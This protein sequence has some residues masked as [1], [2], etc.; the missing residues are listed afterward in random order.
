MNYTEFLKE[1]NVHVSTSAIKLQHMLASYVLE[2][3][4]FKKTF[5]KMFWT[6]DGG[7]NQ[8]G[9][10]FLSFIG[11]NLKSIQS[12]DPKATTIFEAIKHC[13]TEII[14]SKKVLKTEFTKQKVADSIALPDYIKIGKRN[15]EDF[16]VEIFRTTLQI[17][18]NKFDKELYKSFTSIKNTI[19]YS[20]DDTVYTISTNLKGE[21]LCLTPADY[22]SDPNCL[23][24]KITKD[25]ATNYEWYMN[26][27]KT[28]LAMITQ[29]DL[30]AFVA[31]DIKVAP[32]ES[33][34]INDIPTSFRKIVKIK[35]RF[36]K[37]NNNFVFSKFIVL[38]L[39]GYGGAM[40]TL[41]FDDFF[42]YLMKNFV[43][44]TKGAVRTQKE[45]LTWSNDWNSKAV[46]TWALPD[47]DTLKNAA[48]PK[49]WHDFLD[50][51]ASP[52]LMSRLY[53]YL[54]AIQD[55]S[56][57]AQQALII[58]D[59]GGT[60]K[61]VIINVLNSILPE[62]SLCY[63]SNHSLSENDTFGLSSANVQDSH[64]FVLTEYD[65]ESLNGQIGKALIA[66][67]PMTLNVKNRSSLYWSPKG[68]KFIATSN[69]GC[70]LKENAIRR[71]VIPI[72]FTRH[73]SVKDNFSNEQLNQ[74]KLT[75]KD[76]LNWCYKIYLECSLKNKK[77]EYI[78]MN[79][80][81][82]KAFLK[83]GELEM[84]ED[85]RILKAFSED[86][87]ISEHFS[88][89]DFSNSEANTDFQSVIDNLYERTNDDKDVIWMDDMRNN[90]LA[91][92]EIH[93]EYRYSFNAK[94]IGGVICMA[95]KDWV[96]FNAFMRSSGYHN[97]NV[98]RGKNSPKAWVGLKLIPDALNQTDTEESK[99]GFESF[100]DRLESN[101]DEVS[102]NWS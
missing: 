77:G 83:T 94:E 28:K 71:R 62:R 67:D 29:E 16:D 95:R 53:F 27:L 37:L 9:G 51:K 30:D 52:R 86:E 46:S 4:N 84:N 23:Y 20:C 54:G 50:N 18:P 61:G 81:Q 99:G 12:F 85:H 64:L 42:Q 10:Q 24:N 55:A 88:V 75:A 26:V 45:Y 63:L 57:T 80:E 59:N 101:N 87:E 6:R 41:A 35:A 65:G 82:E 89:N 32:I 22:G 11:D 66:S 92:M 13:F 33:I 98:R 8:P 68:N 73:H 100:T 17:T 97:K 78:V 96:P 48:M 56:N 31:D 70:S 36:D 76:F 7:D 40:P 3:T 91:Y 38:P 69:A 5:E 72:S 21:E 102:D 43:Q 39:N 34:F 14:E 60:G 1:K 93:P 74:L 15:Y 49:C 90:I 2:P 58:S 79:P 25:M 44:M 19:V 47:A